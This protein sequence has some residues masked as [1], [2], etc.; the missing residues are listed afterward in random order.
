MAA[1]SPAAGETVQVGLCSG[2]AGVPFLVGTGTCAFMGFKH[3]LGSFSS[4][5]RLSSSCKLC[6]LLEPGALLEG[7][8][9]MCLVC[10]GQSAQ[11]LHTRSL[12]KTR[13]SRA[14]QDQHLGRWAASSPS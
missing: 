13:S 10:S 14:P 8:G 2:R 5:R 11:L 9:E 4:A 7:F 12:A 1:G 6:R 3:L